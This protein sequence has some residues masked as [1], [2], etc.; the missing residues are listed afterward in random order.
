MG[1]GIGLLCG[2]IPAMHPNTIIPILQSILKKEEGI[3]VLITSLIPAQL[4]GSLVPSQLIKS[5]NLNSTS[6]AF[7]KKKSEK[8][9]TVALY[10]ALI[11]ILIS[12]GFFWITFDSFK[13]LFPIIKD[14]AKFFVLFAA[15]IT[16]LRSR[17]QIIEALL[18]FLASGFFGKYTFENGFNDPFL[19]IFGG[20][21]GVASLIAIKKNNE[22]ISKEEFSL[23]AKEFLKISGYC[24]F[25]VML[26]FLSN[27]FPAIGSPTLFALIFLPLL[28]YD[29]IMFIATTISISFSQ[30]I[31]S[32]S[33]A[34]TIEKIRVGSI[35]ILSEIV[36]FESQTPKILIIFLLSASISAVIISKL[37]LKLINSKIGENSRII[38]VVGILIIVGLNAITNGIWSIPILGIFTT[39][40]II[41]NKMDLD[42]TLLMGS[43]IIPTL[44]LL[45]R[46]F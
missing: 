41:T 1:I 6:L 46:I 8:N 36:D 39:I 42:K 29:K 37:N 20:V 22:E 15:I 9:F 21:F 5:A 45:F 19:I 10:C 43:I 33:S 3:E 4:I 25:G 11:S 35:A 28:N 44:L 14:Y 26:G 23:S 2:L 40:G 38:K 31:F 18:I 7:I 16:L 27:L 24:L 17:N 34:I 30:V 32:L 13:I 12:I